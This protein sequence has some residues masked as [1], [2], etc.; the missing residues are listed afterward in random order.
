M[1]LVTKPMPFVPLLASAV[2]HGIE[3]ADIDR[4][5]AGIWLDLLRQ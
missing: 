5:T 2:A 4:Q 3:A 1:S